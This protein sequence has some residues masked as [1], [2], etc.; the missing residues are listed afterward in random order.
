MHGSLQLGDLTHVRTLRDAAALLDD[1]TLRERT[2]RALLA[3]P[4]FARRYAAR[5]HAHLEPCAEPAG[6]LAAAV[7]GFRAFYQ[8]GPDFFPAG[9]LAEAGPLAYAAFSLARDHDAYHVLCAY[10]TS[11]HDEIALQS[12][13]CAQAPCVFAAFV[14]AVQRS[15][16]VVGLRYKHLRDL[17]QGELDLEAVQRGL[18]ARPLLLCDCVARGHERLERLRSALELPPR[19]ALPTRAELANTC[20]G[21]RHEPFF[22]G[23]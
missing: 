4:E 19:T 16:E 8:L 21:K 11:D 5:C 13:L 23:A 2:E 10:E 17:L 20:G 12:L 1:R 22:G 6:S 9:Q 14:V 15:A 18:R 7:R 3:L